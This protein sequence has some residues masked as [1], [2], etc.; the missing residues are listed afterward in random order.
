MKTLALIGAATLAATAFGN[1]IQIRDVPSSNTIPVVAWSS[2][3]SAVGIR[4]RVGRDGKIAGEGRAGDHRFY[5]DVAVA[6]GKGGFTRAVALPNTNLR[7][8]GKATDNDACRFGPCSPRDTY[9]VQIADK[10]LREGKGD[11]TVQFRPATGDN[12]EYT[13]PRTLIDAYL[14]TV[15]S[16]AAAN[17]K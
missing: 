16:I 17:K 4:T 2:S 12:F 14:A 7:L 11:L 3:E 1:V 6:D 8:I 10:L 15:D 9:G 13:L 5:I